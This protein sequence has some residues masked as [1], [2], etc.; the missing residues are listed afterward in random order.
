MATLRQK[1]APTLFTTFSCA[2]FDWN[3]LAHSIYETVHKKKVSMEEIKNMSASDKN[4]LISENVTQSTV[5][6][7]KRTDKLMSILNKGGIFQHKG[8]DFKVDSYFYRVEFQARGAPHIHCLLWLKGDKGEKP[9]SMCNEDS[10]TDPNLGEKIASFCGS[11]MSGCS[12]DMN[13]DTHKL[14]N[15]DCVECNEG[16]KLVE[17]YQSH[18][19]TFSCHKKG[20]IIRIPG[21]EGHGRLDY[22]IQGQDLQ[23][24]VC[25]LR[26]PKFPIDETEFVFGFPQDVDEK[27][28][29]NAKKDYRKIK[30]YLLR[31]TF[32]EN[33]KDSEEWKKFQKFT[34]QE[35]LYHV[36]MFRDGKNIDD[37]DEFIFARARY[38]QAI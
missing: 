16:K 2:E 30:R 29:K 3:S 37:N 8:T 11:I 9:P 19:H 5:H 25:R 12:T 20:K 32:G 36:G 38:L 34:F 27:V 31:I 24:D 35:F 28:L 33:F 7:A 26:H 14:F 23:I 18:K 4:K 6:F 22:K 10:R 17:K 1:G 15:G 13:C 21:T